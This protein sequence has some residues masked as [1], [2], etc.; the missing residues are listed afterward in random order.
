MEYAKGL[1]EVQYFISVLEIWNLRDCLEIGFFRNNLLSR[2]TQILRQKIKSN[3][4]ITVA[5]DVLC[6]KKCAFYYDVFS[7]RDLMEKVVDLL[8]KLK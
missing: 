5:V 8:K 1:I 7:N 3:F 2:D 6:P 4:E